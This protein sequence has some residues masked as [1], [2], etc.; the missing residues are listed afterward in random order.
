MK[1]RTYWSRLTRWVDLLLPFDF[2]IFYNP[3]RIIGI[4]GYLSRHPSKIERESVKAT[5][6]WNNWFT[7]NHVNGVKSILAEEYR[8]PIRGRQWIN[9]TRDDKRSKS[10]QSHVNTCKQTA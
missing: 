7:V 5:N 2:E 10:E 8:V 3:G 9:L 6:L 4:A 1:K